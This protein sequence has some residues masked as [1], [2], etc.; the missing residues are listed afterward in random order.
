MQRLVAVV[1]VSEVLAPEIEKL[2]K[3][4]VSSGV[5]ECDVKIGKHSSL[6]EHGDS[7]SD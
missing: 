4:A 2:R 6:R 3:I 5:D 7:E 1:S